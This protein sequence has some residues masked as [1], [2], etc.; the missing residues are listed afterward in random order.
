MSLRAAIDHWGTTPDERARRFPCDDVL[1]RHEQALFRAVTVEAPPPVVFRWLC[2]MKVAPYSYDLLDNRGRRSPQH[3]VPGVE[4]LEV[5]QRVLIFELASF[6]VDEHLTLLLRGHRVFGDVAMSYVVVP[7]GDGASRLVGKIVMV[8]VGG[9]AGAVLRR[10]LPLGDLVMMRRQLLNLKALA[11]A[12]PLS[13]MAA[14]S[15]PTPDPA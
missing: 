12:T 9:V 14:V 13:A 5:G 11:E 2:Q 7:H 4:Q 1:P 3:L 6:A 15:T 10:V 8:P